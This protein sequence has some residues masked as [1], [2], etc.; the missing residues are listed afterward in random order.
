MESTLR[1][2]SKEMHMLLQY[3]AGF[4]LLLSSSAVQAGFMTLDTP[5]TCA[6]WL[7]ISDDFYNQREHQCDLRIFAFNC[8][9]HQEK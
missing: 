4:L 6:V 7:N 8:A 5:A 1:V 2:Y 9:S 3:A